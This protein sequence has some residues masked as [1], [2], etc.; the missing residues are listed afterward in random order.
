MHHLRRLIRDLGGLLVV[1]ALMLLVTLLPPDTSLR[2]VEATGALRVC[3]PASYPPLVTGDPARPGIDVEILRAIAD[4][5][6]AALLVTHIDAMGRDFNPR[7]W[8]INRAKCQIVAGGVV[9]S[10]LTRSFLDTGPS[11]AQTG[12]GIVAPEPLTDLHGLTLGALTII[13][14]LD[15]IGLSSY[16]RREEVT[17][18]VVPDSAGFVG[19]IAG[20]TFDGGVTELLLARQ[21]AADNGWW[22]A[23]LKG[24]ARYNLVFGLWK[25][26][27]TLKRRIAAAFRQIEGDGS[28]AAILAR[29]GVDG[30]AP[31]S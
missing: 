17:T 8:A 21:I 3:L 28:L 20:G 11:Y 4:R 14:G 22:A 29:Y 12:W 18:R 23:P 31:A 25:G 2:E 1:V 10:D 6:G 13:S 9:D 15:R 26:D 16:L 5:M 24:L 27:I 30:S 19:G 7:H